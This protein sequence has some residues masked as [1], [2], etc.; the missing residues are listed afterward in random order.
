MWQQ[1]G[2]KGLTSVPNAPI[3]VFIHGGAWRTGA[4]RNYAFASELFVRA[5]AHSVVADFVNV[6]AAGGNL[7]PMADQVRRAVAWTYKNGGQFDGDPTR[8]YVSGH[9]SGAHLGGVVLITDWVKEFGLPGDVVKG[10]LLCSGIYD[11]K[12]VRL[13]ARSNYVRFTDEMEHSLRH[14]T[15]HW[16]AELSGDPRSRNVGDT[17]I[18]TSNARIRGFASSGGQIGVDAGRTRLQS[19][20]DHRNVREPLRSAWQRRTTADEPPSNSLGIRLL[21]H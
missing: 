9:S 10:A 12:P 6:D 17:R 1:L 18:S 8:I 14:A 4:A 5:G 21:G 15:A 19:L 7:M 13:S 20:R 16:H 11:L 3:N 2:D